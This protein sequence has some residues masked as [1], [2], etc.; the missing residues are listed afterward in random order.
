MYDVNVSV[1]PVTELASSESEQQTSS[2]ASA[3]NLRADRGVKTLG[4]CMIVKNEAKVILRCL[5]SVRPI[6]DHVLIQD[7]GSTD[8]TQNLI[9]EWLERAGLP[10]EVYD[11]PWRDFAYNRSHA[12]GKLREQN[13]IDYALILDADDEFV[14]EQGFDIAGFK[15]G[16][17]ADLYNV[18][19]VTGA[20]LR[21]YQRPQ[22]CSNRR[23]FL[24]RGV[25]H[26][27]IDTS[28]RALSWGSGKVKVGSAHGF[29]IS[30][31]RQGARNQDP[32]KYRKDAAILEKALSEEKDKF[33]RSRHIFYLAR[34]YRDAGEKE[35]ALSYFLKR[36]EL[37][38]WIDEVYISLFTAGLIQQEMGK[39]DEALAT[40]RR[41]SETLPNR[42]EAWHAASRLCRE[43]K[44]F[45]EGYEC[46]RRGLA[47]PLPSGGLFVEPWRYEYGLLD[48]LAV[49]A[50]W[51]GKHQESFDASQRLLREGKMPQ[52]M[53]DRI[54]KNAELAAG[55]LTEPRAPDAGRQSIKPVFIHAATRTSSTW[56]WLKF[57]QLSST[58]C[59]YEPFTHTLN[60]LTPQRA[61]R[62][63]RDSWHS[64]H[65][66]SDPYYLEYAA[67]LRESGGVKHFA[68][69]MTMQ[70][71]L[72]EGG[73]HGQLRPA[74]KDYLS[75]LIDSAREAGKIPVFGDCWSLGRIWAIKQLY[76]G[77]HIF[78]YRNL[79]QQ[80]LS[81]VS[82]KRRNDLTFYNTTVD[83]IW[84]D[85][86]P[87]FQYLVERGLKYAT[88]PWSGMGPKPS[89]LLWNRLY[90][91]VPRDTDKV[92]Q[93]ETL[94]EHHAFA[95]FMGLQV[96]LY[97]HAQLCADLRADVTRMARDEGYRND[98]EREIEQKT[99]LPVSF[100]DV[101]DVLPQT[102]VEFDQT[103]VDWDEIREFGRIAAEM[104]GK[105][106]DPD[107]LAA[108]A[109]AFIDDTVD[110]MRRADA[111][112]AAPPTPAVT[113][114]PA[115]APAKPPATGVKTIGL[116]M[117]VKNETK[118]IRRCL[119]S[120]LPLVDYI[121][122]VDTGST[123]GT[124]QMIRDFL[125][126]KKVDGAVIDEPWRDFAYNRSFALA[127]LREVASVDYVMIID[128]DDTLEIDA[129]FD[130]RAFKAQLTH[131]LY[132]VPVRHGSIAHHRPQLFSNRL[133]FSFKGVL[134]EYLEAPPGNIARE[135]AKGFAVRASTGG[136][137]SENPRKYQD[138]AAVLE[139]ALAT[140]TNPFLISRYTF[141]LAQSYRDCGE[142]EKALENYLK[143]AELGNWNEEIYVSL[144]EAGNLMAALGSPFDE[145]IGTWERASQTVPGRAE[146]VH[147][148]SR[149]CRDKGK[150][151]QGMDI[152]RRGIDLK[153]T[154]GL[155]VQPW[156]YDYGLLDEFAINAY[157]A[158]A[159][160]ESLDACL[161]L[162]ASDKLPPSMI[163]RVAANARFATDKLP[164]AQAPNL[165]KH[166][167]EDFV[168]QHAM[169]PQRRLHS[170][171]K[172]APRVLVAILAKQKEPALPLYLDCI[173]ALDYPK[174][175]IV[176]YIRTNNNTD[177]SEQ[178]LRDWVA[179]VGHLYH[180]VEFDASN[181]TEK[182]EQFR[183]HEWNATR[184]SVLGRIRNLSMRRAIELECEYYFVA[185]VDN[186]IRPATLRELVAL[187][188]PIAAP[189][190]RAIAPGQYY[191][192]LHAEIDANGYYQNGD[193][194]NWILN[195]HI[196]GV[197]EVPVVHCT[198][199]VR[200]DIIPQ[201]TYED[202]TGR[203]EYVVFSD[204]ARKASI[205]Q[206]FDNRQIYG[207]ITFGE[208]D[209]H[210]VAGGIDQARALLKAAGDKPILA[211]PA[212]V[213]ASYAGSQSTPNLPIHL[214]NLDRST[215]RL[216]EFE[217]YNTHLR[218]VIRVSA[219]DGRLLDRDTLIQDGLVTPD[220]DYKAGALACALSH[221]SLWKKA[222]AE[223]IIM[224]IFEDD[225]TATDRFEEKAAQLIAT[226]PKDWDF[227]QWGYNFNPLF[228]WADF[229]FSKATLRF[230]SQ[231]FQG[232]NKSEFQ[233]ASLVPSAIKLAHSYGTVAYSISP[234]G[235]D[236]FLK[237]CLPLRKQL[238]P[239]PGTGIVNVDEGI[240]CAMNNAYSMTQAFISIPPLVL[241][242]RLLNSARVATDDG[243]IE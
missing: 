54:K 173:E 110:E 96:Y 175:S 105:Y 129:D 220:C 195:R 113:A 184:F 203:H 103:S 197:V 43:S 120:V 148:A 109:K 35:K 87:Y 66:K 207:Y 77:F 221:V 82:Y 179:K 68:P 233:S 174:S 189:F 13:N 201:L 188:L 193:Q 206:Y 172:G 64:R 123:D 202:G 10:G 167:E 180:S 70:W 48:E 108:N 196:R 58:C 112:P 228:V 40:F 78:Q 102:A 117:I 214:I 79:W 177:K 194:Y 142:R 17:S 65:P 149:Y 127:K 7:T 141:Y 95:L 20:S 231:R 222:V 107:Q 56:F 116:C 14:I 114:P 166:G 192:N 131:E 199:L 121:L 75:F 27:F 210:Y 223:N 89:P 151:A 154:N 2:P 168:K 16:L 80:W 161:R 31:T 8:G 97:L 61:A 200:T 225:A 128:A 37:G 130:A 100:A 230:Y 4:L 55:K 30:S 5:E 104:L 136:A 145:V 234:K 21:R 155:F 98:I 81:F 67:L 186:F 170:G 73:L 134:H 18:E 240:D 60:W 160:R 162:L 191:S 28:D 111:K 44:R 239:F 90:E 83:I 46:A 217:K 183:E 51:T 38:F 232:A 22:I 86:D 212:A 124:Q 24:Y 157:W 15:S 229:G 11:E 33:L 92:R 137:R 143:R 236:L 9:R 91:N 216:A 53:L 139:R 84:R 50:F 47:I 72:P 63:G 52:Q 76:G 204:S 158:G 182:V 163:Q 85:D 69:A 140:E 159:Y 41:A 235:A 135:T 126:E 156:V 227:M 176:L 115:P 101:D 34:S 3:V 12:L 224:T 25:L 32:D 6:V 215:E 119:E 150:N 171:M 93:I 36:A 118:L 238:I 39:V 74:E 144:F 146:A 42:A 211:E 62:L 94:P 45:A 213:A 226:L 122:V 26:E 218:N 243:N 237:L 153:Q 133:P 198:Y 187:D 106:G 138:D 178:I 242:D 165:G 49:N 185:D 1:R 164:A 29:Y 147:A 181:V 152:A 23:E 209:G 205:P 59:F 57:R 88:E 208:G 71:F 125:A 169:L 241:E 19:L 190:L 219:V 132:D 99:G